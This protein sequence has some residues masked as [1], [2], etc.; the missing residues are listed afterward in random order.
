M[1]DRPF[2]QHGT[3]HRTRLRT[4]HASDRLRIADIVR[5]K[6]KRLAEAAVGIPNLATRTPGDLGAI[7]E[8][9]A[10][11]DIGTLPR[12]LS[13]SVAAWARNYRDRHSHIICYNLPAH[14]SASTN[15][16]FATSRSRPVTGHRRPSEP[17]A[18]L[19]PDRDPALGLR[20]GVVGGL[21][22]GRLDAELE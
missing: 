16:S 17:D 22:P 5:R 21:G 20:P 18:E 1:T 11:K 2:H 15:A 13:V 9:V 14:Q 12:E 7:L 10:T 6:F 3:P 8:R 19:E 4:E